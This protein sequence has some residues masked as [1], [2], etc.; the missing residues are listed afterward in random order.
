MTGLDFGR[1]SL[2]SGFNWDDGLGTAVG[3]GEDG[4]RSAV[5]IGAT[6]WEP[7]LD[8]ERTELDR[9]FQLGR[10]SE[11]RGWIGR[12]RNSKSSEE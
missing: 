7:R 6:V 9:R 8:W 12:G 4:I 5:S 11:N 10:R 2:D 1:R 3:L